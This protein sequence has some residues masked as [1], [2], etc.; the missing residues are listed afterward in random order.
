MKSHVLLAG[1]L[2]NDIPVCH[3]AVDQKAFVLGGIEPDFNMFSYLK[4]SI[5]CQKLRGH[6]YNSSRDYT[7]HVMKKL[8]SRKKWCLLD[9]YRLGKLMHYLADAFTCTHNESFTGTLWEHRI[10][11]AH[12]HPHLAACLHQCGKKSETE[13]LKDVGAFIAE[14]HGQ[15]A[16]LPGS[17][18]ND[19]KF[20]LQATS[21]VIK[22]LVSMGYEKGNEHYENTDYNRLVCSNHQWG[23]DLGAESAAG[24]YPART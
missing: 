13:N 2:L 9:Y 21:Q 18:H 15:Y 16:G 4:G 6:N 23:C 10:Y 8:Q 3:S 17:F 12:L 11:E 20:I 1:Y 22:A 7:L 5:K 19:A 14:L 24:A